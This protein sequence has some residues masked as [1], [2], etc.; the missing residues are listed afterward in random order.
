MFPKLVRASCV[1]WSLVSLAEPAVADGFDHDRAGTPPANWLCGVT[2]GGT[3]VWGV[4]REVNAPSP[5]QVLVQ[6]GVGAFPWCVRPDVALANGFVEVMFKPISGRQD[7]AGGVIWRWTDAKHYYIARANALENNV[8]LYR[9]EQGRRVTLKYADAPVPG[10]QWSRL[11]VE[12][13]GPHI[14]V[15]LNRQLTIELDDP[16]V[17]G[18]GSVGVW[19]KADST[20]AFDDFSF[21]AV[22]LAR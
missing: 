11:R 14:R 5:P 8:A 12:F 13:E 21:G 22:P 15:W 17:E 3:P 18:T 1:A 19:T 16:Q 9:M 4:R 10:A 2:G 7:Q 20:T 6:S